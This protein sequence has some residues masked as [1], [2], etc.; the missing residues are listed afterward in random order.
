VS[1]QDEPRVPGS[2]RSAHGASAS[3]SRWMAD[4]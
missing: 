2:R 3:V 4:S 1:C